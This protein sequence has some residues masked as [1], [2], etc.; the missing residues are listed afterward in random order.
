MYQV[1]CQRSVNKKVPE[2]KAFSRFFEKVKSNSHVAGCNMEMKR[3][4]LF[5]DGEGNDCVMQMG[6]QCCK[7]Q[8]LTT[9]LGKDAFA[10][11]LNFVVHL[12]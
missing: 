3:I 9:C 11:F 2:N 5:V 1:P 8:F 4:F 12:Q 6:R 7:M 10:A